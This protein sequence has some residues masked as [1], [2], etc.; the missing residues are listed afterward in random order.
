MER[1]EIT[2]T[3]INIIFPLKFP[4]DNTSTKIGETI[5]YSKNI[6]REIERTFNVVLNCDISNLN[7]NEVCEIIFTQQQRDKTTKEPQPKSS[8][9]QTD[10]LLT[11]RQVCGYILKH[12]GTRGP[13]GRQ[14]DRK[15]KISDLRSE[16]ITA[17]LR[18]EFDDAFTGILNH[19][20]VTMDAQTLNNDNT[21]VYNISNEI[22]ALLVTQGKALSFAEEF[23]DIDLFF[24][25]IHMATAFNCLTE[26]L[27]QHFGFW[28]TTVEGTKKLTQTLLNLR[29]YDE[30]NQFVIKE[31]VKVNVDKI[32]YK[33]SNF[34]CPFA[35]RPDMSDF[36]IFPQN[37]YGIKR[38]I[39]TSFNISVD[40]NISGTL[41]NKLYTYV[42]NHVKKSPTLWARLFKRMTS[43]T[44]INNVVYT[45]KQIGTGLYEKSY[46]DIADMYAPW[47]ALNRASD[48]GFL[49][50]I[51]HN[52]GLKIPRNHLSNCRTFDEYR[53]LI[54]NALRNYFDGTSLDVDK[55]ILQKNLTF[56]Q[57]TQLIDTMQK[58]R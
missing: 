1:K 30:Y 35:L 43:K 19:F 29:S 40:Y 44:S 54:I 25:P 45:P 47:A 24:G 34:V 13:L 23:K 32:L 21:R 7:I 31:G 56:A 58:K 46:I 38:D 36:T 57:Y 41:A 14:I 52:M 16:A 18:K 11:K 3:L 53:D 48:S 15:E 9:Q 8:V 49:Y 55:E 22:T 50:A 10:A 51:W 2:Q 33:Y 42:Y 26:I 6:K 39:E 5:P 20:N 4:D 17:G 28:G 12:L 37:A 27:K